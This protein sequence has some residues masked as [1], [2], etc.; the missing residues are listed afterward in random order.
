MDQMLPLPLW[1]QP[2]VCQGRAQLQLEGIDYFWFSQEE[3]ALP[4]DI[5][6]VNA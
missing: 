6:L 2:T 4:A 3:T 1:Y 5:L